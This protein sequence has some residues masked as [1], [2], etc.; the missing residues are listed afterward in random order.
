MGYIALIMLWCK[1]EAVTGIIPIKSIDLNFLSLVNKWLDY[2]SVS[3][4][5]FRK[6]IVIIPYMYSIQRS[7]MFIQRIFIIIIG[8]AAKVCILLYARLPVTVKHFNV[9]SEYKN[10]SFCPFKGKGFMGNGIFN[11]PVYMWNRKSL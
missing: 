2:V 7:K 3:F 5:P 10:R 4:S 9:W 6:Y 1:P 8:S 11:C